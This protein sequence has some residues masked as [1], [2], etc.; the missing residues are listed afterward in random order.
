MDQKSDITSKAGS[1]GWHLALQKAAGEGA[2]LGDQAV[3]GRLVRTFLGDLAD[4]YVAVCSGNST[5]WEA[6]QA[7]ADACT[8]LAGVLNGQDPA[9]ES[10]GE[11]NGA[12]GLGR[13]LAGQLE[14][15]VADEHLR[16]PVG[17]TTQALALVAHRA[18]GVLQAIEPE[19]AGGAKA[20]EQL[21]E[22]ADVATR[23]FLGFETDLFSAEA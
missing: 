15:M 8:H 12:G 14:G 20:A 9:F 3:V 19:A 18:Y 17:A 21:G 22:L 11:W 23:A 1:S 2:Y 16:D 6:S 4:R 5:P 13:F 10:M 7:D